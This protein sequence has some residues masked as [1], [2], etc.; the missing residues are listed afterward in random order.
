[1][2]RASYVGVGSPEASAFVDF[3]EEIAGFSVIAVH[4][5]LS[6]PAVFL[7]F[8][9]SSSRLIKMHACLREFF[10]SSLVLVPL[11]LLQLE[12]NM[13]RKDF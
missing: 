4:W 7:L 5:A 9:S 10:Y 3:Q 12:L 13:N 6:A 8:V 2:P 11:R 1:M